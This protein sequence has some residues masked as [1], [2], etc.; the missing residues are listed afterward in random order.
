M[1]EP[2]ETFDWSVLDQ[3]DLQKP[4]LLSGGISSENI[5]FCSESF[6]QNLCFGHQPK[7]E[8][9]PRDKN[10]GQ[11]TRIYKFDKKLKKIPKGCF[12]K[13]LI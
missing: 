11:N 8:N 12:N 13:E 6:K 3:L 9:S 5:K 2:G 1:A 10:L 7:F 4:Y